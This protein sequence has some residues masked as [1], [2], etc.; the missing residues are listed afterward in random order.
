MSTA[1]GGARTRRLSALGVSAAMGLVGVAVGATLAVASLWATSSGP[2]PTSS[3]AAALVSSAFAVP[4][5][6]VSVQRSD[7]LFGSDHAEA[8]PFTLLGSDTHGPGRVDI[9]VPVATP[10]L[11]GEAADR[12]AAR[13][14]QVADPSSVHG[15]L[16]ASSPAE[17]L[18]VSA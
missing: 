15:A 2:L 7:Y 1:T 10:T 14:F 4:V 8:W 5:D 3:E 13:G 6:A 16:V 11:Y 9:D 12:L 18:V 17:R